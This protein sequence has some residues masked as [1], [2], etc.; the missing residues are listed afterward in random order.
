MLDQILEVMH[1]KRFKLPIPH[2]LSRCQ[3]AFLEFLYP[4]LLRKASPLNR[5]QLI[6]LEEGNT[7][8][9]QPADQLFGLRHAGFREGIARYLSNP[10]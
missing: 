1:R 7:G 10:R 8:N 4:R 2:L 5:D 9:G 3:A 6:M